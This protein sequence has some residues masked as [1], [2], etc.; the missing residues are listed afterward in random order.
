[1]RLRAVIDYEAAAP[2]ELSYR[3]GDIII[4]PP[5]TD[6]KVVCEQAVCVLAECGLAAF[7][8]AH[9]RCAQSCT[10]TNKHTHTHA[11]A[12]FYMH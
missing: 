7:E 1:V 6:T 11:R 10:Q 9:T 3:K 4:A 2:G 12:Y 8:E 5:G